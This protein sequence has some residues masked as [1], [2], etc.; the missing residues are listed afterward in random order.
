VIDRVAEIRARLERQFAPIELGI[1]DDSHRHAGH[2]GTR[3]GRG[4]FSVRIV[5]PAFEGLRPLARHRAVYAALGELMDTDIHALAI[6]ARSP[7]ETR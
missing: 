2:A 4:H 5:S 6:D 3:D 1:S 7:E